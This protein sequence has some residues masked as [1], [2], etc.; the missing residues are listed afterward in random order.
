VHV[1]GPDHVEH[2]RALRGIAPEVVLLD[3]G[4]NH[5]EVEGF[6]RRLG[7]IHPGASIGLIAA[8]PGHLLPRIAGEEIDD[9][10]ELR[11]AP[12][13][14]LSRVRR[15]A[16]RRAAPPIE[17]GDLVLH[18]S[19]GVALVGGQPVP[20]RPREFELLR[21]LAARPNR[22]FRREDLL[23]EVWEEGYRGSPRTVD[24][25]IR[26]LRERLGEFGR[27]YL[28]TVRGVGYRMAA[29][30]ASDSEGDAINRLGV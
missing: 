13:E 14:V 23:R 7:Q 22:V 21:F 28:Q 19:E 10:V 16:R 30:P 12:E 18:P 20:L 17:V 27:R 4:E 8:A 11:A 29:P 9:M 1:A 25:H 6:R 26:R 15:A 2:G 5:L 3:L 24:T